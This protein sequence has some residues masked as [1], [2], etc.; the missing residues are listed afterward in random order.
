MTIVFMNPDHFKEFIQS[1]RELVA[2]LEAQP[3][4]EPE[5]ALL[6]DLKAALREYDL[7]IHRSEPRIPRA[8]GFTRGSETPDTGLPPN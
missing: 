7:I 2:V 8:P 3:R 5:E 4:N 6:T 1:V